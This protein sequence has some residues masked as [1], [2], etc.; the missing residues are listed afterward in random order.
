MKILCFRVSSLEDIGWGPMV[1]AVSS[2]VKFLGILSV[3]IQKLLM[4]ASACEVFLDL[5]MA[6]GPM[7]ELGLC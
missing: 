2:K 3:D 6:R 1:V 7:M 4:V 5:V